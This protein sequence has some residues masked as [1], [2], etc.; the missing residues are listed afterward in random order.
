MGRVHQLC[1]KAVGRLPLFATEARRRAVL[2]T[3]MRRVSSVLVSFSLVYEHGHVEV[4]VE[5]KRIGW[6]CRSLRISLRSVVGMPLERVW[7]DPVGGKN[8]M[9]SLLKYN[10]EQ[11]PHH[12]L[13]EHPALFSG[14][15]FQDVVGARALPGLSLR[16]AE[17]APSFRLRQLYEW[18]GLPQEPIEPAS[19]DDVR[20]LGVGRIRE[21]AAAATAADPALEGRRAPVVRA[22][23][24]VVHLARAV[25]IAT[26]EIQDA[27]G[28]TKGGYDTLRKR[29]ADPAAIRATRVRLALEEAV[30]IVEWNRVVRASKD[31]R[32][33]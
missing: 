23:R 1:I 9:L 25:G 22:K 18:V 10:A 24:A 4:L 7:H 30:R 3:L 28:V 6:L 12:G 2:H 5:D 8:H 13:P 14:S 26:K 19:D 17:A 11:V 32:R 21:A 31:N 20:A 29:P 33:R 16:L 15:Y 27:V